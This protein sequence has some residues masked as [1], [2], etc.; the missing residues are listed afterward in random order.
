MAGI[1]SE[2]IERQSSA[3]QKSNFLSQTGHAEFLGIRKRPQQ[4]RG[5][6]SFTLDA[7]KLVNALFSFILANNVEDA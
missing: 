3:T 2:L 1:D 4:C 7:V 5:Q 6:P